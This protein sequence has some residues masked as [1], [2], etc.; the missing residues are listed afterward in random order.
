MNHYCS[1]AFV[2]PSESNDTGQLFSRFLPRQAPDCTLKRETMLRRILDFARV[3]WLQRCRGN[4]RPRPRPA[5][6]AAPRSEVPPA[7]NTP[8]NQPLLAAS[9]SLTTWNRS[10]SQSRCQSQSHRRRW[11]RTCRFPW[12]R[13]SNSSRSRSRSRAAMQRQLRRGGACSPGSTQ[14]PTLS[15]HA[16][17]VLPYALAS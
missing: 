1:S 5:R 9:S 12:L 16:R 15:S 11:F 14:H 2:F 13:C 10:R 3:G 17:C 7:T 4:R 6:S 8:P